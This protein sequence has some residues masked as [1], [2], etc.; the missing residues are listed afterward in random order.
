LLK[1]PKKIYVK[2]SLPNNRFTN[3]IRITNSSII[4]ISKDVQQ[5][6]CRRDM[7]ILKESLLLLVF[8]FFKFIPLIIIIIDSSFLGKFI[9]YFNSCI[10][11]ANTSCKS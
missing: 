6:D 4:L 10:Y 1:N 5:I 11:M 2:N 7:S 8:I 3:H 9:K